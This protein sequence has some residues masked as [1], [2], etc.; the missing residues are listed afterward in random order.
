MTATMNPRTD[1]RLDLTCTRRRRVVIKLFVPGEDAAAGA[2]PRAGADRADPAASTRTR[3]AGCCEDVLDRFGGR[4]RDLA[5]HLPAPLRPGPA[6]ACRRRSSCPPTA[7]LLIGAYFS[8]EYAVEAAAL[9]N[10]SMVAAPGPDRPRAGRAA[11]RRSACGRSAR[12]TSRRSGSAPRSSARATSSGRGPGRPADDR[13]ADRRY[14]TGGTCSPPGWPRRTATTRS[15]P[16]CCPPCPSG[17][18]TSRASSDVLGHLPA[19]LL[20][21]STTPET[22]ERLRRIVA[23]RLRHDLPRRP[24]RCTSGCSGRPPRR[25]A[26]AWRTPGSSGL[27]PTGPDRS[28]RPPTPRTTGGTSPAGAD[29]HPRPAALRGHPAARAGRPQQG[30]GAVPAYGRRPAPGAVPLRRRDPRPDHPGRARTAG[31]TRCRCTS[32]TAAGS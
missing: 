3:S 19:E 30:H 9:C 13:P 22:L 27:E 20:A 14:G 25:R 12:G 23:G 8:H 21:R 31:R 28:T 11:G 4:H 18:T 5:R 17:T 16:P 29:Q 1:H 10:P 6:T 15:P 24:C 2:D 7:R 26:T 32:R